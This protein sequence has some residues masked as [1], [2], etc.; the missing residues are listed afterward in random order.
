MGKNTGSDARENKITFVTMLG[1]EQAKRQADLLF[2][3]A[4]EEI[5]ALFGAESFLMDLTVW[6]AGRRQ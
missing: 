3:Q 4:Q 6:L 5:S 2:S 1:F